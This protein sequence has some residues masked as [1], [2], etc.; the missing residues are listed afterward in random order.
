M[1]AV[2]GQFVAM[3]P[4]HVRLVEGAYFVQRNVVALL[5][6]GTWPT[7]EA[8]AEEAGPVE[9]CAAVAWTLEVGGWVG[10][11]LRFVS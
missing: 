10:G 7:L 3:H 1:P 11:W 9:K 6:P 4:I 5:C 8:V 2:C